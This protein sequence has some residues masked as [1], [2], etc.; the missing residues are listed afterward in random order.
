MSN[1]IYGLNKEIPDDML[2][3][4]LLFSNLAD[5]T[6]P[7]KDLTNIFKANNI[8][9]TY[10]RKIST[11]DAF[12]RAS[13]A[14]KNKVVNIKH[15]NGL[16]E[17]VKIEI[18]EVRNSNDKIKRIIGIK[19]ID[20]CNEDVS[21]EPIG[22]IVFSKNTEQC[23]AHP[24]VDSTDLNYAQY[25]SL[26]VQCMDNYN[27]WSVYHNKDT[28]K[29]II[30]RIINDTHPVNLMPT[31]LCKFIP[32]THTDLLYNLKEALKQMNAYVDNTCQKTNVI[33]IIPVIDTQEQRDL[34][35][36]NFRAE[37]TD[38]LAVFVSELKDIIASKSNISSRTATAY[39]EKFKTLKSKAADYSNLLGIYIQAITAQI[40]QAIQMVEDNANPNWSNNHTV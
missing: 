29:N 18:D 16:S 8:P 11:S 36:K 40:N 33:E 24:T 21:Y 37:I 23:F 2:L 3:G 4:N 1:V 32:S 30:N 10:I 31:G 13:S 22:E 27:E 9:E 5:M 26:C 17:N 7:V 35:E 19:H 12:R 20:F 14:L 34:I 28:I 39:V 15:N 6:I 38:E 25:A